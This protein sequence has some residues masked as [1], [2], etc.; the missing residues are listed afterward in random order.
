MTRINYTLFIHGWESI[1]GLYS[2]LFSKNERLFEVT[3][4][5]VHRKSGRIKEMA[6]NRHIV[7]TH[8]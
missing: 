2:Q 6:R 3:G 8:H 1:Y 4:S 5:H 7:T